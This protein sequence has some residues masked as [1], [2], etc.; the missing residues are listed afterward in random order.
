MSIL[1]CSCLLCA[2]GRGTLSFGSILIIVF[3]G[4]VVVIGAN[5]LLWGGLLDHPIEYEVVF[6][7]H[8]VEEILKQLPQV[9]NVRLLLKLETPTV[10]EVDA[11]LVGQT[12]GQRL[13]RCRQFLVPNLLILLLLCPGWQSLPR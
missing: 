2:S 4:C 10:V 1:G 9:A 12:L 11:K 5:L 6:I 7:A 8:A 13:Y 3:F